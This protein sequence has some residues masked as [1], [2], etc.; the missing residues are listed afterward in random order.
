MIIRGH[1]HTGGHRLG[2]HSIKSGHSVQESHWILLRLFQN[3]LIALKHI[4]VLLFLA[5]QWYKSYVVKKFISMLFTYFWGVLFP[6]P[7][8]WSC[9]RVSTKPLLWS[10]S[11]THFPQPVLLFL[12]VTEEGGLQGFLHTEC[13]PSPCWDRRSR[14]L[15]VINCPDAVPSHNTGGDW[16]FAWGQNPAH[17]QNMGCLTV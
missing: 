14:E 2:G 13:Y 9:A 8:L 5:I 15:S 7:F 11:I 12:M 10:P 6:P 17:P 3:C 16:P 1:L 4:C